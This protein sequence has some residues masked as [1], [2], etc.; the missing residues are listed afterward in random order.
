MINGFE[1][2]THEL[3]GYEQDIIVPLVISGLR[4]KLNKSMA[5]SNK[6]ICS[7][8]NKKGYKISPPRLR[9]VINHIRVNGLIV[10]LLA[11]SQGYYI[12]NDHEEIDKY[13]ESLR[14]RAREITKIA[15]TY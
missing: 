11:N 12:S 14:Q 2:Q 1:I 5:A 6:Y 7:Q 8:L 3:T 4:T 9:K 13:V 15:N 10:N